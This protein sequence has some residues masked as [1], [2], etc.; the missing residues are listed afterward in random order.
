M[1]GA[2]SQPPSLLGPN[3]V[4]EV[5][6]GGSWRAAASHI[7]S[8]GYQAEVEAMQLLDHASSSDRAHRAPQ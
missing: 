1:A 6:I 2:A 8:L 5:E 4:E 7:E 3:G